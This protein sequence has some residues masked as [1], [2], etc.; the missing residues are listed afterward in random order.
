[1][2]E[3]TGPGPEDVAA[4]VLAHP[5]VLRLD[6]GP[7]GTVASYLPGLRVYGVRLGDPVEIAVVVALGR[8]FGEIADEVAARVRAVLGDETL[9]VEV[10]VAD[11]GAVAS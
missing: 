1:M 10:T 3:R 2:T 7:F 8:P 11:V 4:A 5:A 9:E 6:G